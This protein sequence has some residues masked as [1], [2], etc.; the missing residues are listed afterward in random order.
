[1]HPGVRD[2]EIWLC[3]DL[4]AVQEKVDVHEPLLPPPPGLR[5][6]T[7]LLHLYDGLQKL[8]GGEGGLRLHHTIEKPP[9]RHV[10]RFRLIERRDSEES[11]P[12]TLREQ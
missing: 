9:P 12:R 11:D 6:A 2:L 10:H 4:G 8:L 3:D 7:G 5:A 1:M